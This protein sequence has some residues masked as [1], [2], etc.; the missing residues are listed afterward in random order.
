MTGNLQ[1]AA[2]YEFIVGYQI[3]D[4]LVVAALVDL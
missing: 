4:G 2:E 3:F 1:K